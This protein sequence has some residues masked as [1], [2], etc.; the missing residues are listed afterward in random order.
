MQSRTLPL[1][2][3]E[4][5]EDMPGDLGLSEKSPVSMVKTLAV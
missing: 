1:Q 5:K 3:V 4:I 2:K